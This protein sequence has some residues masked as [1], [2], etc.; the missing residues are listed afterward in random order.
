MEAK[1]WPSEKG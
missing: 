1:F